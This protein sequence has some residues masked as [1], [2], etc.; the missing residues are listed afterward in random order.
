MP[1][2]VGLVAQEALTDGHGPVQPRQLD[3]LRVAVHAD[4]FVQVR[5]PLGREA[6]ADLVAVTLRA[7]AFRVG[8]VPRDVR[9][10]DEVRPAGPIRA[11]PR[12]GLAV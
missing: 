3:R 1:R 5:K 12:G 4:G 11:G 6:E 10:D 8:R 9:A 2:H 7:A